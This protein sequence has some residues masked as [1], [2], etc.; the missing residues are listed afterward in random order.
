MKPKVRLMLGNKIFN[1]NFFYNK[2]DFRYSLIKIYFL[3]SIVIENFL[4]RRLNLKILKYKKCKSRY[5]S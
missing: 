2:L 3:N 4:N 5:I 1:R